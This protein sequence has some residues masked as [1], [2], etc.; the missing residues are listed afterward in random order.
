MDDSAQDQ[1]VQQPQQV[2]PPQPQPKADEPVAQVTP[3]VQHTGSMHKEFAP[4]AREQVADYVSPSENLPE[5]HPEVAEAGVEVVP[6]V[7]ELTLEDKNLGMS[8]AKEATPVPQSASDAFHLAA[9]YQGAKKAKSMYH[10]VSDSVTWLYLLWFK[11]KQK[12]NEK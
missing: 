7:K 2:V 8:L 11:Q 3:P 1:G 5:L 6:H 9:D 12:E 10:R 4:V